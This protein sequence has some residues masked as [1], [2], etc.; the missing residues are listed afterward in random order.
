MSRREVLRYIIFGGVVLKGSSPAHADR[1]GKYSTKLTAKRRYL[2]RIA[3]GVRLINANNTDAYIN[4]SEDFVTALQLFGTTYFAEGNRIGPLEK[5]LSEIAEFV[6][7]QNKL[8]T[9]DSVDGVASSKVLD[10][11]H[12][13]VEKY[14]DVAKIRDSLVSFDTLQ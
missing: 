13:L 4:V 10:S 6:E 7:K 9:S 8:L 14:I 11:I 5:E 2:P 3:R 1:T 12:M